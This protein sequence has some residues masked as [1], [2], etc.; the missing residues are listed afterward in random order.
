MGGVVDK[1]DKLKGKGMTTE[2]FVEAKRRRFFAVLDVDKDGQVTR[3]DYEEFGKRSAAD[4]RGDRKKKAQIREHFVKVW[5]KLFD[6]EGK[7]KQVNV[8]EFLAFLG[9]KEEAE[10]LHKIYLDIASLLFEVVDFDADDIIQWQEF[11]IFYRLFGIANDNDTALKS[12]E[13]I[14]KDADGKI[15][16]EELVKAFLDFLVGKN[17]KSPYTQFF[18]PINN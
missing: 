16:K 11:Q 15:N 18:G 9:K 3:K 17:Q 12:F 4:S 1:L 2:Q 7:R 6:V 13:A 10:E 14:D 8:D 5:E